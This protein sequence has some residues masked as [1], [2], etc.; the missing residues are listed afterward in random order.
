M[1]KND[2]CWVQRWKSGSFLSVRH[3]GLVDECGDY[4]SSMFVLEPIGAKRSTRVNDSV[5]F[6][7]HIPQLLEELYL[8]KNAAWNGYKFW[9]NRFASIVTL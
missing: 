8:E 2:I 6:A 7:P 9:G 5:A 1:L 3:V 4:Q